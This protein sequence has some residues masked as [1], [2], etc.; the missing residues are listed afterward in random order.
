MKNKIFVEKKKEILC[1]FFFPHRLILQILS[2]IEIRTVNFK[3]VH[4]IIIF[5]N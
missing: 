1:E 3:S 5:N 2:A 4:L